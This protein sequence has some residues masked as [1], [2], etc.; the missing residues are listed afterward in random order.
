MRK[1][2]FLILLIHSVLGSA[3]ISTIWERSIRGGSNFSSPV[4]TPDLNGDG[5]GDLILASGIEGTF[6]DSAIVALSG[7]NGAVLWVRSARDQLFTTPHFH[8][9]TGDDIPD[10]YVGGRNAQFMLLNGST[11]ESIWEF[12]S[13][14]STN[15]ADSGWYNFYSPIFT[16]DVNGD[17]IPELI[18]TNGGDASAKSG[19]TSRPAGRLL[20]LD[21]ATGKIRAQ[22]ETPD[23]RETYFSPLI[24]VRDQADS[25]VLF[26]T[27][28]ETVSGHLY[29]IPLSD[30]RKEDTANIVTLLSGDTKGFIASPIVLPSPDKTEQ[31][32]V[33]Q[34]D[35]G[36][37]SLESENLQSTLIYSEADAEFYVTPVPL[38][39]RQTQGKTSLQ[40]L[41]WFSAQGVFP[42]YSSY[43]SLVSTGLSNNLTLDTTLGIY[44]LMSPNAMDLDRDG[45]DDLVI[46]VNYDI[47]TQTVQYRN[48]LFWVNYMSGE[49]QTLTPERTGLMLYAQPLFTD[50]DG[51]NQTDLIVIS[52][53]NE[54]NWYNHSSYTISRFEFNQAPLLSGSWPSYRGVRGDARGFIHHQQVN[55]V[56]P[57]RSSVLL[58]PNPAQSSVILALPPK[59]IGSMTIYSAEGREMGLVRTNHSNKI[60]LDLSHLTPGLYYL[61]WTDM[62]GRLFRHKCIV[63]P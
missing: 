27:G 31:L 15:P 47:G 25:L 58:Y 1:T 40:G 60:V 17:Q 54:S 23:R 39:N 35:K 16:D 44:E 4:F 5:T 55:G 46:G 22:I 2:V 63:S 3:Q 42:F 57:Q 29:A 26:G 34:L 33:P 18:L 9:V 59:S 10:V 36:I 49:W 51:N 41:A 24:F 43:R 14:T 38:A 30:L 62:A 56:A 52:N 50:L 8:D 45:V 13:D 12:W 37:I 48:R 7:E 53:D 6:V 20:L 32:I 19:D 21:G 28:G 11:G 61:H